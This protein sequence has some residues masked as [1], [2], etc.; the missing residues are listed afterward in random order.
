MEHDVVELG[1]L[2]QRWPHTATSWEVTASSERP[3]RSPAKMMCTTC[4]VKN[5]RSGEIESMS[6]IG[7]RPDLVLDADPRGA[8]GGA[9][10]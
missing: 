2:E 1:A 5:A 6:A 7:P 4:F 9:Q 10:P 3:E 8:R